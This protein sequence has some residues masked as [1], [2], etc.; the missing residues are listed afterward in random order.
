MLGYL[1][2]A[3]ENEDIEATEDGEVEV[4][5]LLGGARVMG[6]RMI[7]GKGSQIGATRGRTQS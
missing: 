1:R 5:G 2:G 3:V 7:K 6:Q 4:G